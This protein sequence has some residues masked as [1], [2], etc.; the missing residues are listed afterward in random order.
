M[1]L[2]EK[3]PTLS[4]EDVVNLL[5]NARRLKETGDEKQR[6]AAAELLPTLEAEA[7]ER[8]QAR[9]QRAQARR[10]ARRPKRRA[11]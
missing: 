8:R 1:S 7:E 9:L 2:L 3:I 10:A 6:A 4:D 5:A 11:A